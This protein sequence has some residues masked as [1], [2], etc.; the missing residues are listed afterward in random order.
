[1]S[2]R[3]MKVKARVYIEQIKGLNTYTEVT[4]VVALEGVYITDKGELMLWHSMK[5]G[6]FAGGTVPI[7]PENVFEVEYL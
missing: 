3:F 2:K 4:N 7:K 6:K 5:D 1:M